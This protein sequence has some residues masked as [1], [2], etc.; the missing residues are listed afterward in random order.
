MLL[1]SPV[2]PIYRFFLVFVFLLDYST[3]DIIV[4]D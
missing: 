2:F 4:G 1:S 3:L